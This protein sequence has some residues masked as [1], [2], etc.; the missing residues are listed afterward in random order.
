MSTINMYRGDSETL[1]LSVT[2]SEGDAFN[3]TGHLVFMTIKAT[4][5]DF[6]LTKSSDVDGEIDV[7]APADGQ[8]LIYITPEDTEAMN[9]S[10]AY[11][12]D[13]Q[14]SQSTT[15]RKTILKGVVKIE[16]DITVP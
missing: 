9:P 14:V 7:I 3:L 12:Y 1:E 15:F 2:N 10:T 4:S 5:G 6:V 16:K 8:A 11:Q 13:I